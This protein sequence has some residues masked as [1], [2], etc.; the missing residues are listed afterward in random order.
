MDLPVDIWGEIMSYLDLKSAF[1]ARAMCKKA[2]LAFIKW[3]SGRQIAL[4]RPSRNLTVN[5]WIL[6]EHLCNA[7]LLDF[8]NWGPKYDDWIYGCKQG[9]ISGQW[10]SIITP[11]GASIGEG[12]TKHIFCDTVIINRP[13][14]KC[15]SG[16]EIID[17]KKIVI[18]TE[19]ILDHDWLQYS[20]VEHIEIDIIF[21]TYYRAIKGL[22]AK[23][24]IIGT[25]VWLKD[26][27]YDLMADSLRYLARNGPLG[28]FKC[29]DDD[30]LTNETMAIIKARLGN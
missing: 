9:P 5:R 28:H 29:R 19:H 17:A 23:I 7:K 20:K 22:K 11:I 27:H 21:C 1:R 2:L 15:C 18:R 14:Y 26:K 16:L 13:N 4:N 30:K 12:L 24:F 3:P 25:L 8:S 6:E 10:P